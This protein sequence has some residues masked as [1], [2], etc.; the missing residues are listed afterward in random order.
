MTYTIAVCTVRNTEDGQRNC[1]KHVE[2]YSKIK[3]EKFVYLVCFII[4]MKRCIEPHHLIW[5]NRNRKLITHSSDPREYTW[6]TYTNTY[7]YTQV[8]FERLNLHRQYL[9]L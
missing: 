8:Q 9:I 4:R 2:F 3:F 6:I 5:N 1:P 7:K